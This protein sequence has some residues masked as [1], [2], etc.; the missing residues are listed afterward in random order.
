M[1]NSTYFL[2]IAANERRHDLYRSRITRR[3]TRQRDTKERHRLA[4]T[5]PVLPRAAEA[6]C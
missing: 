3:R 2:Q 1:T 4:R 6:V 5:L